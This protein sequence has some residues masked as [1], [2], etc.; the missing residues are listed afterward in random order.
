MKT[1]LVLLT[2]V[3][4]ATCSKKGDMFSN[5]PGADELHDKPVGHSANDLLS[6]TKY[7]SLKIEIQYLDNYIPDA[8][9][10]DH[11]VDFLEARLNKT[12]VTVE[13]T[14]AGTATGDPL[15]VDNIK[16]FENAKRR[17][18]TNGSEIAVYVLYTNGNFT[19]N[20]VL[21]I[22][23]R[24]TSVALFG[25]KIHE[26]SGAIGQPSRT[27]L[28]ATVLEHEI[29][30]LLGL[31]DLGS[32]MQTN[33]KDAVNGSHCTSTTCLMYYGA[34]TTDILGFLITGAIPALDANCIADLRANGGK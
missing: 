25:K 24:N 11:L 7:T 32:P 13:I 14:S 18:F 34:E 8:A 31:V 33:H 30:H 17:S 16:V 27:K 22:A 9:A 19:N 21:G 26:N 15:S 3:L 4:L 2:V 10:I 5:G 29:G 12:V 20:N 23:Y 6:S 28:E 1:V